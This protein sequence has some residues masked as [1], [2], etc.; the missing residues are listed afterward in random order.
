MERK[1]ATLGQC[2][3]VLSSSCVM[4]LGFNLSNSLSKIWNIRISGVL[5]NFG[6][7][8]SD[9]NRDANRT[10]SSH[11]CRLFYPSSSLPKGV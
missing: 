9:R 7:N 6:D 3:G 10:R 4:K 11:Y 8:L 1:S 5:S 2:R